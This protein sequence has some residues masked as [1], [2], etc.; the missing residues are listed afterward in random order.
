[1]IITASWE[2]RRRKNVKRLLANRCEI[3]RITRRPPNFIDEAADFTCRAGAT[4][5]TQW[6]TEDA[7][8]LYVEKRLGAM[9]LKSFKA[10]VA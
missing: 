2:T 8:K 10:E 5:L 1:M 9:R 3:A 4:R 7:A 6:Q